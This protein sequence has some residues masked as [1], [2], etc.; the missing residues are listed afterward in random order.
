MLEKLLKTFL[1]KE[2]HKTIRN[3]EYFWSNN[4]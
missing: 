2:Q 4:K 3:P 1:E